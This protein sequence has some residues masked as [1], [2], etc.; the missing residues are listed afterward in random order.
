MSQGRCIRRPK[1]EE[2]QVQDIT[3]IMT[4]QLLQYEELSQWR[5][6]NHF[7]ASGYR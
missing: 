1:V 2:S 3:E 7:I 4:I 6:D 5:K